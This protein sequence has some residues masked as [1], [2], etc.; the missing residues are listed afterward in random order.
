LRLFGSVNTPNASVRKILK[1]AKR[2]VSNRAYRVSNELR[3]ASLYVLR[4]QR[5]GRRYNIP[6]TGRV[7]YYKR[8][9]TAEISHKKYQ[10][11][12]P[13][14]APAVRTGIFRLSWGSRVHV[15]QKGKNFRAT[16]SAVSNTHVGNR[17]LGDLLESGTNRMEARPY[18]QAVRSRAMWHAKRIYNKPFK[19]LDSMTVVY[20]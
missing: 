17:L 18:K 20:E 6:G 2:E 13:G 19:N 4:G 3:N 10:A 9:K 16:S 1:A 12:A 11:S 8:T 7:K 14:E 15:E 5:S